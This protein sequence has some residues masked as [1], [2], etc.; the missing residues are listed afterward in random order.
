MFRR[1]LALLPAVLAAALALVPGARAGGPEML[2][3]AADD[4]VRS[5]DLV[6]AKAAASLLRVAGFN[7]ARI[8]V[9]WRTGEVTP[10][11]AEVA[12]LRN[13]EAAAALHGL[14]VIVALVPDG[15]AA[16]PLA[17]DLQAQVASYAASLVAAFPGFDDLVVGE[18]PNA[19]ASGFPQLG[20]DGS[21]TAAPLYL[22][23]L[24]RTYDAVKAVDPGVR[25]WG[26]ALSS[27]GATPPAVAAGIA[28]AAFVRDLGTVYRSSGRQL[29][30][31]DGLVLHPDAGP[32]SGPA[33]ARPR[34]TTIGVADY[35]RLVAALAR[36]FDGTVQLGTDIPV[37]YDGFAVQT[38][39]PAGKAAR[40][41]GS[42]QGTVPLSEPRQGADYAAALRLA[43]CQPTVA[44]LAFGRA[45]DDATLEGSQAG[46]LYA[47][48]TPKSS[49]YPVRDALRRA[50]GG[51]IARCPGLALDVTATGLRFP[52][53]ADLR[54]ARRDVRFT[55]SLDCQ[56]DLQVLRSTGAPFLRR[57]GI[58]SAGVAV[59]VSLRTAKLGRG[60]IRFRLTLGHPV[61]PGATETRD[62]APVALP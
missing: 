44:G 19:A 34:S 9:R 14:R 55:C 16:V 41:A 50:R 11:P 59:V 33:V 2:L 45:L 29:P 48:R 30:V 36:A 13:A 15:P 32:A 39:P 31:M 24:A 43:F 60:A 61:N 57:R 62:S 21:D 52:T 22:Q 18:E 42:E 1:P 46:I 40:Y 17:A 56:W 20:P 53:A 54:S 6:Q 12:A 49:F 26:G 37:L 28:P 10:S 25:V 51:S 7:A 4:G 27:S 8:T 47:D 38:A 5:P 3:G 58:G 35:D 23:V